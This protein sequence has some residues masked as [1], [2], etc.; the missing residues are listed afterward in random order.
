MEAIG[1]YFELELKK[2]KHYHDNAIRLNT[3]RNCL[4]YILRAKK[5]TKI[6]IPYYTCDVILEPLNLLSIS[7]EFYH[8]NELLEPVNDV[9]IKSNEVYLYTNYYGIKQE[10]VTRLAKLY[11]QQ[12]IVDNAQ[13]FFAPP[14]EG[15][16]TFYSA[17]KFFG[18]PDGAYLY[19][20]T[21]IKINEQDVS[22]NRINHLSKRI[23][24]GAE[25]G[26]K[27]FQIND[28]SLIGQPIKKMSKLTEVLLSGIDYV[29]VRKQRIDN[30]KQLDTKLRKKNKI[31]LPIGEFDVP[32]VY[33]Y[34]DNEV[35]LREKLIE[36]KIFTATY[37]PNVL[38]WSDP[39]DLEFMF[40]KSALFLPIDQRYS[41][42]EMVKILNLLK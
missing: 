1:G 39:R 34:W 15:I 6:Y 2:G 5:Y 9:I 33:P 24:L 26:Y 25:E 30:Y 29:K 16:D 3:A 37:W 18:V 41:E 19:T 32:M 7:Y 36:N 35:L 20:D 22:Y 23:E 21:T 10:A 38:E 13:A 11:K 12:L 14:L 40:T 31:Y 42:D 8:I 27:D 28:N 4:E 17:R